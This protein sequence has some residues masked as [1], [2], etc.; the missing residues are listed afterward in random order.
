MYL[1]LIAIYLC[2]TM[3]GFFDI[4]NDGFLGGKNVHSLLI[5]GALAYIIYK[6]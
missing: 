6:K 4:S 2:N 5:L 3:T 1:L